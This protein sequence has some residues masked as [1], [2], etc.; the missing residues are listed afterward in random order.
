MVP[1]TGQIYNA[2]VLVLCPMNAATSQFNYI[3]N[4]KPNIPVLGSSSC[5]Q[6]VVSLLSAS[7][8]ISNDGNSMDLTTFTHHTTLQ[9]TLPYV[10]ILHINTKRCD[11]LAKVKNNRKIN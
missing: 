4:Q 9:N 11:Q 2:G 6:S 10:N 3:T 8:F 7:V 1:F 5:E